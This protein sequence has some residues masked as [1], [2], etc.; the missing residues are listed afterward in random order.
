MASFDAK[1]ASPEDRKTY[2]KNK[3]IHKTTFF[4]EVKKWIELEDKDAFKVAKKKTTKKT[5]A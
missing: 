2:Y 5:K 4:D 1:S 3:I